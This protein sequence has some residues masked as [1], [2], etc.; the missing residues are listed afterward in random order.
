MRIKELRRVRAGATVGEGPCQG[1]H[2]YVYYSGKGLDTYT[3]PLE[4]PKTQNI[5]YRLYHLL[6]C[7]S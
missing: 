1:V 5:T 3:I 6:A 7:V 2:I 4:E